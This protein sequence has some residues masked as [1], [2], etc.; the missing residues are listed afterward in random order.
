[1]LGIVLIIVVGVLNFHP[2]HF[3][4]ESATTTDT[5][6]ARLL[7]VGLLADLVAAV[8]AAVGVYRGAR[9][10]WLLGIAVAAVG[11]G[12]YVLQET[13]GLPGLPTMWWEPSR[14]VTLAAEITFV[15]VALRQLATPPGHTTE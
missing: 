13:V 10:G 2:P 11:A 8:I 9:W 14:I 12:L 1:M 4:L 15:I 5:V 3:L 6:G 7:E